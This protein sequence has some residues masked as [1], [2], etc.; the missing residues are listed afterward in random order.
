MRRLTAIATKAPILVGRSFSNVGIE[1]L[2]G[3]NYTTDG[4]LHLIFKKMTKYLFLKREIIKNRVSIWKCTFIT[5]HITAVKGIYL[6]PNND[7]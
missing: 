3:V 2:N 5:D 4:V 7:R 1:G 6:F